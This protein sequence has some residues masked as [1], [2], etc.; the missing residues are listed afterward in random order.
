MISRLRTFRNLLLGGIAVFAVIGIALSPTSIPLCF[1]PEA[2]GR[3]TVV[4]P[5]AETPLGPVTADEDL[6]PDT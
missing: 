1:T 5:Q 4:C 3:V 6:D 2:E